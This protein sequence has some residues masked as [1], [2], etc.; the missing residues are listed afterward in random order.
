MSVSGVSM[1]QAMQLVDSV[2]KRDNLPLEIATAVLKQV[3]D[4]QESQAAA[5]IQMIRQSTPENT[6]QIINILT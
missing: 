5:L 6:G 4:Q 3:Q 1:D 2:S